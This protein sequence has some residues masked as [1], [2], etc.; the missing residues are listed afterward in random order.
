MHGS[1]PE[2]SSAPAS[3]G[4]QIEPLH[5][6]MRKRKKP[7]DNHDI[8][9]QLND[10]RNEMMSFLTSFRN[11]QNENLEKMRQEITSDI[12]EQISVVSSLSQKIIEEQ[13]R[14]K[15]EFLEVKDRISLVEGNH[16][17][18]SMIPKSLS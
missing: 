10:F 6:T 5:A 16:A 8:K 15:A 18:L 7:E 13:D 12:K 4:L 9:Q 1:N 3:D 17:A 2:L 14:L 11:Q